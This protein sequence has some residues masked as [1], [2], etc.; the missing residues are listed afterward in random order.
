MSSD[1]KRADEDYEIYWAEWD[2]ALVE[3]PIEYVDLSIASDPI[4]PAMAPTLRWPRFDQVFEYEGLGS[5]YFAGYPGDSGSGCENF[6]GFNC[7]FG[8]PD[9]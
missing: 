9:S 3:K 5:E 2:A 4:V 7:Y 6:W 8:A 1:S